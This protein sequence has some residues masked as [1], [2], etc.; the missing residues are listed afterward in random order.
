MEFIFEK[1]LKF[2]KS[3]NGITTEIKSIC[4]LRSGV[5]PRSK[6]IVISYDYVCSCE[7][8]GANLTFIYDDKALNLRI[9]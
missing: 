7:R 3:L 1:N 8:L 2:F 4:S 9:I 5:S 6:V